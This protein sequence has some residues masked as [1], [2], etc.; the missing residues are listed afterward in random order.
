MYGVKAKKKK[1]PETKNKIL[2]AILASNRDLT[3]GEIVAITRLS[4]PTVLTWVKVLEAEGKIHKSRQVGG[5]VT[6][7]EKAP[8]KKGAK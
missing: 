4:R 7:W 1:E 2:D 3:V 5:R 8:A 6:L